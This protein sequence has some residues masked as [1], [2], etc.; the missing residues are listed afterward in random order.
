MVFT[1]VRLKKESESKL[2][3]TSQPFLSRR[4]KLRALPDETKR[5][6]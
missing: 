2:L 5:R 4:A 3:S 1:V 6:L